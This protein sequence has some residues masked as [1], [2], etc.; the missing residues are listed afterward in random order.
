[1]PT[2]EVKAQVVGLLR[3]VARSLSTTARIRS[4]DEGAQRVCRIIALL[5]P[6]LAQA[7]TLKLGMEN[8]IGC[9]NYR[10]S[11]SVIICNINVYFCS[12]FFYYRC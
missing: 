11:L 9:P 1:M 7:H 2:G 8:K 12:F 6:K 4:I 3:G 10:T 5:S